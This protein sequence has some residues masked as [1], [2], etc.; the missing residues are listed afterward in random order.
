M[1]NKFHEDLEEQRRPAYQRKRGLQGW[2]HGNTARLLSHLNVNDL[3][4]K[5][6]E[7]FNGRCEKGPPAAHPP[8]SKLLW[9]L[10]ARPRL[11][12]RWLA[13]RHWEKDEVESMV[14]LRPPS[15]LVGY[16]NWV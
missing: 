11:R 12:L 2:S 6:A 9:L 5:H 10:L 13:L 7:H 14:F 8:V 4:P 1:E 3:K 15:T 16:R